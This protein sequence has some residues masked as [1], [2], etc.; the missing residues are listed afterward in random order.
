MDAMRTKILLSIIALSFLTNGFL[1][2]EALKNR[3]PDE[4][5]PEQFLYLSKRI[6]TENQNDILI[7]FIPLRTAL[8]EYVQKLPDTVGVYFEYLPSGTSIGVNDTEPFFG[9]SLVKTPIVMKVYKLIEQGKLTKDQEITI[10]LQHIDKNFGSL[11]RSGLGTTIPLSEAIRLAIVESDNTAE[12]ILREQIKDY[13]FSEVYDYID[14]KPDTK[15]TP[16][17]FSSMLRSL[18]LSAYLLREHSNDI[19]QTMATSQFDDK[20]TAGVPKDIKVAHKIGLYQ[21]NNNNGAIHSD[22]G[23]VYV[24]NRPYILC[25]MAKSKEEKA[26][27]YMQNISKMIYEYTAQIE[28][29][30]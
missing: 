22:C 29:G 7:N 21:P 5:S 14:I 2:Y 3:G 26:R 1:G 19:L 6:F 9:A 8:R 24:P 25:I 12:K 20:I 11:W 13:P 23:I 30:N 18:Y 16:K 17:N 15:I 28:G 10:E 27:E 4:T